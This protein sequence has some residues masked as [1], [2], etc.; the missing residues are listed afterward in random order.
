MPRGRPPVCR[1]LFGRP[2]PG[3]VDRF[4]QET[5]EKLQRLTDE[6]SQRWEFDFHAGRPL[7]EVPGR[8][9][10]YEWIP[11]D[12]RDSV[13]L[14]YNR[15]YC[16]AKQSMTANRVSAA[17]SE[18]AVGVITPSTSNEASSDTTMKS[19]AAGESE[20]N[21]PTNFTGPDGTSSG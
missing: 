13:P 2:E 7:Y 16:H 14:A 18:P 10:R 6:A 11:V 4:L 17:T 8:D 9:Q 3:D 12:S 19:Q 5:E 15:K 1:C 20:Q 21:Q